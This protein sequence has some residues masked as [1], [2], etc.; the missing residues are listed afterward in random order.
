MQ[1]FKSSLDMTVRGGSNRLGSSSG[2]MPKINKIKAPGS[3]LRSAWLGFEK[4]SS[5][6]TL[7]T[8]LLAKLMSF[9]YGFFQQLKCLTDQEITIKKHSSIAYFGLF[10][11][12]KNDLFKC[13]AFPR[14]GLYFFTVI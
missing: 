11:K 6:P 4:L 12:T 2:P 8:G 1:N 3:D 10:C 14:N 7:M 9:K 13:L 5:D